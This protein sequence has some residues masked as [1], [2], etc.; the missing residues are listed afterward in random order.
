MQK[1]R[2]KQTTK[3]GSQIVKQ[4]QM[5]S[6]EWKDLQAAPARVV[7]LEKQLTRARESNKYL[8]AELEKRSGSTMG[9]PDIDG[10]EEADAFAALEKGLT[11]YCAAQK[12]TKAV[13][14]DGLAKFRETDEGRELNDACNDSL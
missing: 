11:A 14:T 13:W 12:I 6:E 10:L 3:E 4:V 8:V 2:E 9:P 7:E 5:T 1:F